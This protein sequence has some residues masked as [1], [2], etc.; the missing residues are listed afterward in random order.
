M[1]YLHLCED[2]RPLHVSIPL[3]LLMQKLSSSQLLLGRYTVEAASLSSRAEM[4]SKRVALFAFSN[5]RA[6][7][8]D[9]IPE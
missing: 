5:L 8:I 3:E 6:C 9:S 4:P 1:F 7:S 2:L